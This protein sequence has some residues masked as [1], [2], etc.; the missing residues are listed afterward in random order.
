MFKISGAA[1]TLLLV[2]VVVCPPC[3][4]NTPCANIDPSIEMFTVDPVDQEAEVGGKV[5]LTCRYHEDSSVTGWAWE[6]YPHLGRRITVRGNDSVAQG[7]LVTRVGELVIPTLRANHTGDYQC[8]ATPIVGCNV[9]SGNASLNVLSE[10]MLQV[11]DNSICHNATQSAVIT[12]EVVGFPLATVYFY[13]LFESG[14][15]LVVNSRV[16]ITQPTDESTSFRVSISD[17]LTSDQGT[18]IVQA[19]NSRGNSQQEQISLTV[20]GPDR[21]IV[22]LDTSPHKIQR[23]GEEVTTTMCS[24]QESAMSD[25]TVIMWVGPEDFMRSTTEMQLEL[26]LDSFEQGESGEY[27]CTASNERDTA[28]TSVYVYAPISLASPP[29]VSNLGE[30]RITVTWTAPVSPHE[31]VPIFEYVVY[32][33]NDGGT[34]LTVR[35][36]DTEYTSP[37]LPPGNYEVRVSVVIGDRDSAAKGEGDTMAATTD[38]S[39]SDKESL[40]LIVGVAVG[41]VVLLVVA[42]IFFGLFCVCCYYPHRQK[43]LTQKQSWSKENRLDEADQALGNSYEPLT[44]PPHSQL[45]PSPPPQNGVI[46]QF[47]NTD[48]D[49]K[50]EFSRGNLRMSEVLCESHFSVLYKSTA[51]GI[52][53][54]PM[55]VTVKALRDNV[56][57]E[58]VKIMFYEMDMLASLGPHPNLVSLLR[59]CTVDQPLYM[60]MEYMSHGDLLGFMRA[61]RGHYS[62]YTVNPGLRNQQPPN[63]QLSSRDL[64]SISAKV[65]S[66]MR[67]LADRKVVHRALCCKN[68]LVAAGMEIKIHNIGGFDLPAE[69]RSSLIKWCSPEVLADNNFSTDSDVWA[70]GVT[71]WEIITVGATPYAEINSADLLSQLYSGMRMPR[72]QHCGQEVYDMMRQCWAYS[73]EDRPHFAT[74]QEQLDGLAHSKMSLL[75]LRHYNDME[76]S[77]FDEC[78]SQA[79]A[80]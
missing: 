34:F 75:D 53:D 27:M 4:A 39:V 55:D 18:Y 69:V 47:Y 30:D 76:Y 40:I 33:I 10:P 13:Q 15:R 59:V 61:S 3:H 42:V 20:K 32:I 21:P 58:E 45:P 72:P 16:S 60:V 64:L 1:L 67:F 38:I 26:D 25:Q 44:M 77:Q 35:T 23:H 50:W 24:I 73:S 49:P 37:S 56:T 31:E 22:T 78:P 70:F 28:S 43:L 14:M 29:T 12:G 66:G 46:T 74:I 7:F 2:L 17:L 68:I 41:G 51:E 8:R 52:K 79:T 54:K 6:F 57:D 36:P 9:F 65:A 19:N 63:L 80:L 48:I 11:V 5:M 62:M 71:L